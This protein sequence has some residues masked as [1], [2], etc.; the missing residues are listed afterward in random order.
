MADGCNLLQYT[1]HAFQS[2]FE[3]EAHM[4]YRKQLAALFLSFALITILPFLNRSFETP[5][6]TRDQVSFSYFHQSLSPYGEWVNIADYGQCWRPAKIAVDF[7]PYY[8][9]GSWVYTEYG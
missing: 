1:R 7:Q 8:T 9:N 3:A 6:Q 5:S 2:F 4:R